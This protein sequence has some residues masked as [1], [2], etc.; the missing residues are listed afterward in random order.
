MFPWLF[1]LRY[2]FQSLRFGSVKFYW[3]KNGRR[4]PKW[5]T[6][7]TLCNYFSPFIPA[8][9]AFFQKNKRK[10]E[11]RLLF[12]GYKP[13]EVWMSPP[14]KAAGKRHLVYWFTT[15]LCTLVVYD[16]CFRPAAKVNFSLKLNA[17][18][19]HL[20]KV[21]MKTIAD[22]NSRL[23]GVYFLFGGNLKIIDC[24]KKSEI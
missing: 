21:I 15:I 11:L 20:L 3:T 24:S 14:K 9:D 16:N 22:E 6:L 18:S 10:Q 2:L 4:I 8:C 12:L 13:I 19:P 5:T 7:T 23:H 1:L 17:V